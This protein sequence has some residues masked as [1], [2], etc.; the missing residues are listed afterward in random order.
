M[1]KRLSRVKVMTIILENLDP[2]I[3]EKLQNQA[4][5]HGRTLIEKIEIIL[6]NEAQKDKIETRYNAWGKTLNQKS[7]EDTIN[8]MKKLRKNVAIDRS[9]ILD[10]KEDGRRF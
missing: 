9:E 1:I 4:I 7:I 8:E 5:S 3:L 2:E 6:I 10:T